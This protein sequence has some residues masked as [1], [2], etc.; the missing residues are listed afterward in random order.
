MIPS[1]PKCEV[2][3]QESFDLV[4]T[5]NYWIPTEVPNYTNDWFVQETEI[6]Q[7]IKDEYALYCLK[8]N[9]YSA[10]SR[11][12]QRP[13]DISAKT[14]V[15]QYEFRAEFAF[16][17]SGAYIKLFGSD[18]D[19]PTLTNETNYILMFGPDKCGQS[20]KVHFIVNDYD[21]ITKKITQIQTDDAPEPIDDQLTHLYTLV[22]KPDNSYFIFIDNEL[23]KAGKLKQKARLPLSYGSGFELWHVNKDLSF[24][25]I[26]IATDEEAVLEW[27]KENFIQR[28]KYQRNELK[29]GL[30]YNTKQRIFNR[31]VYELNIAI[32]LLRVRDI[33]FIALAL[34][35][36]V[37]IN[38]IGCFK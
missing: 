33:V 20:S 22:Y 27:N 28:Q 36:P 4:E 14:F 18:L 25:N 11:R 1:M 8:G 7:T 12:F 3:L 37:I 24:N 38:I 32:Q 34:F 13:I 35:I 16:T 10:I 23:K 9:S 26:L 5:P 17:C 31:I 19:P 2:L 29:E 15:L 30:T 6:P 21:P